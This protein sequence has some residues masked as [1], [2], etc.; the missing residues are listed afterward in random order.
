MGIENV[1][2]AEDVRCSL[3]HINPQNEKERVRWILDLQA[4]IKRLEKM[5]ESKTKRSMIQAKINAL[6][7]LKFAE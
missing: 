5:R 6:L 3:H 2:S 4:S 7:K 1:G